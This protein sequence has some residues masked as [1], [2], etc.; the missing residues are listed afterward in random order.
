MIFLD[1]SSRSSP[2]K[3]RQIH[4]SSA[5]SAMCTMWQCN[6]Y[7]VHEYTACPLCQS[8]HRPLKQC[9]RHVYSLQLGS[10]LII[11]TS[12]C[13]W[14]L[15]LPSYQLSHSFSLSGQTLCLAGSVFW[16]CKQMY[17]RVSTGTYR[18]F[19]SVTSILRYMQIVHF[20]TSVTWKCK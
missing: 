6:V 16:R 12:C 1:I 5:D 10:S 4:S 20:E 18:W 7:Y 9:T 3:P 13:Y 8:L 2:T 11:S 15:Q 14:S 19:F 17:T